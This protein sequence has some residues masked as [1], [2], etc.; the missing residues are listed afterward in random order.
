MMDRYSNQ[1]G[2]F[3]KIRSCGDFICRHVPQSVQQAFDKWLDAG[4]AE[5]K[6]RFQ[7][8][9][10]D[11]YLTSPVW[12]FL[13][14]STNR[15]RFVF[16]IMMPSIDKVGRYY[17]LIVINELQYD[18]SLDLERAAKI[19]A[20]MLDTLS[21]GV[22]IDEFDQQLQFLNKQLTGSTKASLE[23]AVELSAK[24]QQQLTDFIREKLLRRDAEASDMKAHIF[25]H[26]SE[27]GQKHQSIWWTK[28]SEHMG[29]TALICCDF[30]P[31]S[32]I[33]ATL[34]GDWQS[35]G[36][37]PLVQNN[38]EW[39]QQQKQQLMEECCD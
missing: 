36:W 20:L 33:H 18:E 7:Q 14:P 35:S 8:N 38:D 21:S 24:P 13:R 23:V 19:E 4:L 9:W 31:I 26:T 37:E 17:P 1:I 34:D 25:V 22:V 30:P 10:L 3:G 6:E 11:Y 16:G 15:E 12:Y 5:T 32:G 39:Q 27:I 28:G 29:T 2:C